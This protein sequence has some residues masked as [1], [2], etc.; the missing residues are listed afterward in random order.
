MTH[1]FIPN[2]FRRVEQKL[3]AKPIASME[4]TETV[5]FWSPRLFSMKMTDYDTL[6]ILGTYHS[7][8]YLEDKLRPV[9][10]GIKINQ[11]FWFENMY[12]VKLRE[13][14]QWQTFIEMVKE[15]LG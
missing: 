15:A 7:L 11:S 5:E 4:Q 13:P 3:V 6:F 1:S 2:L 12:D 10:P 9:F 14:V 8:I